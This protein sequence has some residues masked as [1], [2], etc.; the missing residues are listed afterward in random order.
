MMISLSNKM[1]VWSSALR[2]PVVFIRRG[3]K[4]EFLTELLFDI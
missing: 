2:N 3:L 1:T 4:K